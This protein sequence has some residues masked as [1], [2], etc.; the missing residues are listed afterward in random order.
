[1]TT[2]NNKAD[3]TQNLFISAVGPSIIGGLLTL[4]PDTSIDTTDIVIGQTEPA[5]VRCIDAQTVTDLSLD[6]VNWTYG[7]RVVRDAD[8]SVRV[9]AAMTYALQADLAAFLTYTILATDFDL[10][11]NHKMQISATRTADSRL[12]ILEPELLRVRAS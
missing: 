9:D 7:L 10:A 2:A 1:M 11:G 3:F 5:L 12:L 6:G 8:A 4:V